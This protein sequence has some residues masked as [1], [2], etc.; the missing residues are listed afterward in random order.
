M[1]DIAGFFQLNFFAH[2]LPIRH[3]HTENNEPEEGRALGGIVTIS[4][5]TE[6][7]PV[8]NS[9]TSNS[10]IVQQTTMPCRLGT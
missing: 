4:C 2:E 7:D 6:T 10:I 5:Q 8:Q 3:I 1:K 9:I